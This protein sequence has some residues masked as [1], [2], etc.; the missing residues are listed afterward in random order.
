[1]GHLHAMEFASMEDRSLG[2]RMHLD[3]NFFPPLPGFVKD[4]IAA[5]FKRHW[6]GELDEEGV[7]KELVPSVLRTPDALYRYFGEFFDNN[8]ND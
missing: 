4:K 3:T 7:V 6:E 5:A 1:M 2:M 8:P